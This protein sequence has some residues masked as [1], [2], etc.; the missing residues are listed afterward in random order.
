MSLLPEHQ[1]MVQASPS[2]A[3]RARVSSGD[4]RKALGWGK[5]RDSDGPQKLSSDVPAVPAI[6]LALA[7]TSNV[8][9]APRVPINAAAAVKSKITVVVPSP[10]KSAGP[11]VYRDE[12]GKENAVPFA[13]YVDLTF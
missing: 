4:R 8:H 7:R 13:R 11:E 6:P 1:S 10:R 2:A 12:G 5:R 9:T 3:A